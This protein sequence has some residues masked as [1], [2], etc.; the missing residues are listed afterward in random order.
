MNIIINTSNLYVGGGVQVALSFINELNN[1]SAENNYHVFV[2]RAVR[3]QIDY[4]IFSDKF[5]FYFI[6]KS[7]SHLIERLK[8]TEFLSSLEEKIMPDVVFTVFGPSYWKPKAPHIMGFANGWLYNPKSIAYT[9]LKLFKRIRMRVFC[10]YQEYYLKRDANLIIVETLDAK[11]KVSKALSI[12]TDK[13]AVVGNTCSSIFDERKY[14][15]RGCKYYIDLPKKGKYEYRFLYITHN[16]PSKNLEIINKVCELLSEKNINFVVT[17]DDESYENMF[18]HNPRVINLGP[19]AHKSCPSI[20]SQCDFLFAPTLLETFSASYPEAMKMNLPILTS[21]YSFA[22]DVCHNAALYF[23]PINP[24]DIVE[25]INI[26]IYDLKLQEA[27]TRNGKAV[28]S[29]MESGRTRA[30]K[31]LKICKEVSKKQ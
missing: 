13:I 7:P 5:K 27:M 22:K 2:S 14:I 18:S 8:I 16:H 11:D 29:Q 26:L 31:Y 6:P 25:K 17:I 20:Y 3:E 10:L 12:E 9:K 4:R 30:E 21:K 1:I 28:L 23:D 24:K 19:V 15:E